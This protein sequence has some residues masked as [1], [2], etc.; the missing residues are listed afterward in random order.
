[1]IEKLDLDISN[2]NLTFPQMI[3]GSFA[4]INEIICNLNSCISLV[5]LQSIR[6]DQIDKRLSDLEQCSINDIRQ[7]QPPKPDYDPDDV[8]FP[9]EEIKSHSDWNLIYNP[10]IKNEIA[11]E[12]TFEW[13]LI[14]MKNDKFVRRPHMKAYI[15]IK[16]LHFIALKHEDFVATDW[17]IIE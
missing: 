15:A 11:N 5:K 4:K 13:A 8:K 17:R 9:K 16:D 14:Q 10:K 2:S 1:M 12:G 3:F 7:C 6:I